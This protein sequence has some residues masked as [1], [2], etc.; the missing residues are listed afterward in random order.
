MTEAFTT[1]VKQELKRRNMTGYDLA[2]E[3]G[4]SPSQVY[5]ILRG[6][7]AWTQRT[8]EAVCRVLGFKLEVKPGGTGDIQAGERNDPDLPA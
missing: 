4:I 2:K 1:A 8:A 6:E 7:N 3:I 5:R